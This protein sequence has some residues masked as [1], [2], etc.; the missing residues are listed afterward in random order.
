MK[1][2]LI[3]WTSL[4]LAASGV[5]AFVARKHVSHEWVATPAV[6]ARYEEGRRIKKTR[7]NYPIIHYSYMVAG[8]T[9]AGRDASLLG[10][11]FATAEEAE[12]AA[13]AYYPTDKL[14]AYYD[15]KNPSVSDLNPVPATTA[16]TYVYAP[17]L[18]L[19]AGYGLA[20]LGSRIK[21]GGGPGGRLA[22]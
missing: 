6:F 7:R 16:W 22:L 13:K 18:I 20:W 19:I 11:N 8:Q 3:V 21:A 15:K 2:S 14:V 4:C 12:S 17:L 10:R 1:W 9:Y 5:G